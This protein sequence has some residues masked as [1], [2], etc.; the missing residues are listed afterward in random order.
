MLGVLISVITLINTMILPLQGRIYSNSISIPFIGKQYIETKFLP[1]NTIGIML[2]GIVSENGTAQYT[3]SE[4]GI[5]F[6]LSKNLQNI[7]EKRKS[8]FL[9]KSYDEINDYVYIQLYV[10][11]IYFRKTITLKRK[12]D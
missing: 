8:E 7:M 1:E 3:V 12:I 10:K 2:D 6:Y 4:E 5:D 11:P 9:F